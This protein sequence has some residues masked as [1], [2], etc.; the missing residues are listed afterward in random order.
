MALL[1][2]RKRRKLPKPAKVRRVRPDEELTLVEHLDELRTRIIVVLSVLTVSLAVAFWQNAA[3]LEFIRQ[4]LPINPETGRQLDFLATGPAEGFL[5]TI[6]LAIYA[7]LLVTL[8]VATY[9]IYAFV[10]PAFGEEHH[11]GLRPLALLVPVL[12]LVGVAFAWFLVLPPALD[13]LL[14]YNTGVF[15]YQ[16]RAREY[17]S[18]VMLTLAAMGIVFELPVV[19]MILGRIGLVTSQMMR[20][21][22]RLAIV[23]LAFVAVLLPGVDPITMLVEF[24]PL[25]ILYWMSYLL[26][27]LSERRRRDVWE[28]GLWPD[29]DEE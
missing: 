3:L 16:L 1:E 9:Q 11:R 17:V 26:V 2:R 28:G 12:F 23:A 6:T 13:F 25:V 21:N 7:S 29:D 19:M 14:N 10:I 27:R 8:P 20:K 15:N 22:W 18:F 24:V 4:P 5:T